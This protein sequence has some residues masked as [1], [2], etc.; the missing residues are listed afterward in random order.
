[1]GTGKSLHSSAQYGVA[2]SRRLADSVLMKNVPLEAT[3]IKRL[4]PAPR[5]Q[6]GLCRA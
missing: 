4:A 1:M 2:F 3:D 5:S 6:D